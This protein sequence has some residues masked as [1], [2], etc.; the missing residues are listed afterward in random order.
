[1]NTL[2]RAIVRRLIP[3]WRQALMFASVWPYLLTAGWLAAQLLVMWNTGRDGVWLGWQV[4]A[5]GLVW[6]LVGALARIIRQPGLVEDVAA[7]IRD[8]GA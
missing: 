5:A 7:E 1:M 3:N 2:Q 6:Q 4:V 8:A